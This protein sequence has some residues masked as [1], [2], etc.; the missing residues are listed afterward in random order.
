[1]L[2]LVVAGTADAVLMVESEAKELSEETM[3]KAV[4]AGHAAF[5]PV[6]AGDHPARRKGRQGA[7]RA[8][9]RPTSRR[10]RRPCS[11]SARPICAPPM[12]SRVKQERYAAVDAVKEKV[13]R[14]A[15]ARRGR[16]PKFA[17]AR[18]SPRPSTTRRPRS[19]AEHPRPRPPHR[20]PRPRRRPPDPARS[21]CCRAPT[22]RRC[23]P[24]A[25][26][27]RWWSP[28]SAPATTSRSS[29]RSRATYKERFLLH[30]NFPPFA[31]ARP[32]AWAR[33]G[34]REIGH[35]KLA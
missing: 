3:L 7:A 27:R 2:D 25:R 21:A 17:Q 15:A 12:R 5:Q 19:C 20:R 28:R 34:R 6:I 29:T 11:K 8:R 10:S 22:A 13:V 9:H 30:Y 33:P 35:G 31:S 23:S 4:M 24:A 18:R 16:A 26:P 1:M 32:A 14:R